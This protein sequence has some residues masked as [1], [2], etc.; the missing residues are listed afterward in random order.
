MM[1]G[2]CHTLTW[3][4]ITIWICIGAL[5]YVGAAIWYFKTQEYVESSLDHFKRYTDASLEYWKKE[6]LATSEPPVPKAH[7]N[8]P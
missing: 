7:D 1:P 3:W 2:V 5:L 8:R 4:E 6:I